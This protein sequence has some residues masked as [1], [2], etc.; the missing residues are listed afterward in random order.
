MFSYA[1][2]VGTAVHVIGD[3]AKAGDNSQILHRY[4][5]MQLESII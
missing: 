5:P 4:K 1:G 3:G 2:D